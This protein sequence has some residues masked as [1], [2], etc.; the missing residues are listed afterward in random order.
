MMSRHCIT[1]IHLTHR[2]KVQNALRVV[3]FTFD[4]IPFLL[5][6]G[7]HVSVSTYELSLK[8]FRRLGNLFFGHFVTKVVVARFAFKLT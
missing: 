6:N 5:M 7:K 4:S 3:V 8:A 1:D 2:R